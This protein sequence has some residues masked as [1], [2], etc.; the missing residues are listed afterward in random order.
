MGFGCERLGVGI[1]PLVFGTFL[2]LLQEVKSH[3]NYNFF[4]SALDGW[5]QVVAL[6][7]LDVSATLYAP[8]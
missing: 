5:S 8:F 4:L 6:K 7:V 3:I 2:L 1:C